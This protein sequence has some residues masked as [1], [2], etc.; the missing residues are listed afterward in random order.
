MIIICLFLGCKDTKFIRYIKR[1][2]PLFC[3]NVK[4]RGTIIPMDWSPYTYSLADDYSRVAFSA[5]IALILSLTS[6]MSSFNFCIFRF[7][8]SMSEL[9]FLLLAVRKPKLFS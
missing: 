5:S 3:P 6:C 4:N 9:P 2:L 1:F 8:S 7:I